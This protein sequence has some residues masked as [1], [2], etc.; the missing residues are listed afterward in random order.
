LPGSEA[1][2]LDPA[3]DVAGLGRLMLRALGP[4][5]PFGELRAA[6]AARELAGWRSRLPVRPER[7]PGDR[8][9]T[10]A[11]RA[12]AATP[13]WGPTA[14]EVARE[15]ERLARSGRRRARGPHPAAP[16]A[17]EPGPLGPAASVA[18]AR[19][20][21]PAVVPAAG[22]GAPTETEPRAARSTEPGAVPW[23]AR[24]PATGL[25][26]ARP[27]RARRGLAVAGGVA[28]LVGGAVTALSLL[29]DGPA[30]AA[31]H[32]GRARRV[33]VP[34]DDLLRGPAADPPGAPAP[35]STTTAH[36]TARVWPAPAVPDGQESR[37]GC[38]PPPAGPAADVDGDG[39]P[40]PVA[41]EGGVVSAGDRR[42]AVG[43][44]DDVVVLGDWDCDRRTTP[45]VLKAGGGRLF[46]FDRWAAPG[47]TQPA[48]PVG[49]PAGAAAVAVEPR[50]CGHA[51][52]RLADGSTAVVATGG[53]S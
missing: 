11:R 37:A 10:V 23:A 31:T 4:G 14:E 48:R 18:A 47:E 9:R 17:T 24:L 6:L 51:A 42:W 16:E 44:P 21:E 13:E 1:D 36:P 15:L 26:A 53:G 34:A 35:A 43:S 12:A 3:D 22:P 2:D 38:G 29:G 30:P 8:L 28:A 33:S 27:R 20:A 39:C 40:E 52:V 45:A 19:P 25:H 41:V 50:G 46:V 49:L 7:R 32:P 5:D